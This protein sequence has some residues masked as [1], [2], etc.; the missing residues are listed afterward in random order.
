VHEGC[1]SY[2]FREAGGLI[3]RLRLLDFLSNP[4]INPDIA[5]NSPKPW[6]SLPSFWPGR[7]PPLQPATPICQRLHSTWLACASRKCTTFL[8][9]SFAAIAL[10][11]TGFLCFKPLQHSIIV[12]EQSCQASIQINFLPKSKTHPRVRKIKDVDLFYIATT[13]LSTS[14]LLR[15]P[16]AKMRFMVDSWTRNRIQISPPNE[17]S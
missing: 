12:L 14:I 16:L 15:S 7:Q 8:A 10:T 6:P 17:C 2:N 11:G 3:Y 9:R 5:S 13:H 4:Y 1:Y